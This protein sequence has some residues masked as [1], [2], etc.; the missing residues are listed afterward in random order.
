MQRHIA[1]FVGRKGSQ[2]GHG[3]VQKINATTTWPRA[4]IE[5]NPFAVLSV[6]VVDVGVLIDKFRVR[7]SKGRE[8][9]LHGTKLDCLRWYR[10][11]FASSSHLPAH[12]LLSTPF[13]PSCCLQLPILTG[14]ISSHHAPISITHLLLLFPQ[15]VFN[16]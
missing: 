1:W 13:P 14:L 3:S 9:D 10:I 2:N 5:R 8:V 4:R 16:G 15:F 11:R 6:V 7:T 12:L